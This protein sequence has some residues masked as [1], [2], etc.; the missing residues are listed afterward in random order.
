[1][2][3]EG[4]VFRP[5]TG[6]LDTQLVALRSLLAELR[7]PCPSGAKVGIKAHWGEMG[8]RSF[9]PAELARE[10]VCWVSSWGGDPFVFDTTVL[11]SGGRRTGAASLQTAAR[12]GYSP[13]LLGC[14][15]V[16]GD[17]LDGR[18]VVDIPAGTRHFASVQVA[19]LIE[20]TDG[21]VVFSHF[22][23]HLVA[24]FGG[25]I[26][27][28]SMGFASRAQKQRMHAHASPQLKRERCSRCGICV[29]VCPTGAAFQPRP[30]ALPTYDLE[31]CIGCAQCIALC[32]EV[33]LRIQWGIDP[34]EFQERL[35]ETAAAVWR[36]IGQRTVLVNALVGIHAECD[37]MPGKN[38]RIAPEV[39][40]TGGY[41]PVQLDED[42]LRRI[43]SAPFEKA[44]PGLPWQRQLAHAAEIGFTARTAGA[45]E[46][47]HGP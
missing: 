15:V 28:L 45:D 8:N 47:E 17:G 25:A 31:R 4:I 36:Q 13:E 20:R 41:H 30:D 18:D 9:L 23:G 43:G 39:G 3:G 19:G 32:P 26:K 1:M 40:F 35:V 21:F 10:I 11:Y 37:C 44:H 24:C 34:Q 42:A 5:A 46:R 27:N 22:K 16:V 2:A 29:Q 14:P 12:H 38:P 7:P 6:G 33:A